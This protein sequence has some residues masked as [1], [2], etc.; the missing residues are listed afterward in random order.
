MAMTGWFHAIQVA[1]GADLNTGD[2]TGAQFKAVTAA[3]V[4]AAS[5]TTAIGLLQ[6]KP[7]NGEDATVGWIGHMKGT[8]GAAIAAGDRLIATTSGYLITA[9]GAVVPC[10]RALTAAASGATVEGI[11]NFANTGV[12]SGP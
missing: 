10:G 6:N 2:G 8:A 5:G 11:F 9:V 4:I 1:A 3:G 12:S 7:K